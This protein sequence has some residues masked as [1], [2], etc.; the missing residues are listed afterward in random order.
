MRIIPTKNVRWKLIPTKNIENAT[1][2]HS[3]PDYISFGGISNDM[4][5]KGDLRPK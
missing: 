5:L 1:F 4:F 3:P 2:G